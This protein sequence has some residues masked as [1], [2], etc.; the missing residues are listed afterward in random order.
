VVATQTADGFPSYQV[1]GKPADGQ[2]LTPAIYDLAREKNWP[3]RE[4]RRDVRTLETV[5]NELATMA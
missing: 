5:F 1:L 4:L 2:D 3:V